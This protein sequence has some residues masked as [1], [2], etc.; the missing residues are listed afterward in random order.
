MID[1]NGAK[2]YIHAVEMWR[3]KSF[4]IPAQDIPAVSADGIL[5]LISILL[6]FL[7][8]AACLFRSLVSILVTV[9]LTAQR[10]Y[11]MVRIRSP[12]YCTDRVRTVQPI[13]SHPIPKY[14]SIPSAIPWIICS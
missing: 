6:L 10:A 13:R 11:C 12:S 2:L 9:C 14:A 7:L 5:Y 4:F 8:T 1:Y 3:N